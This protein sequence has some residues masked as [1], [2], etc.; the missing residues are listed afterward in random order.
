MIKTGVFGAGGRVGRLLVENLEKNAKT[1]LSSVYAQGELDFSLPAETL[2]TNSMESFLQSSEMVIDFTAPEG[3]EELLV[4]AIE[5]C[6]RPLVIG[7]TGLN[8]HQQNLLKEAGAKMPVLYST[9]MSLGVAMLNRLV[10]MASKAL[11][12][13][14]IEITEMH[15]RYKKD[16]PS[17]TALTLAESAACARELSLD[18]VRVSGRDGMIGERKKDEISVMALRGGDIVGEHVVGF[19]ND[20][21]YIRLQHTAT[22]RGTFAIGAIKAGI[23]LVNQENGLYSIQDFLQV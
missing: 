10:Y 12:D 6:P 2:V 8:S 13:F 17:G 21:E 19:Y 22:S 14:D 23:W 18:D 9:N 1:S 11:E 16:A 4:T 5:K 3:T 7:T 20:G 15:H